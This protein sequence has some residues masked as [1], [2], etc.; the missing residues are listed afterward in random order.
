MVI[1]ALVV[2]KLPFLNVPYYWDEAWPYSTATHIM[3]NRGLSFM[4]DAI[5]PFISRGHPLMFFFLAAA[6]MKVFGAG[7]I[8]VHSFALAISAATLAATFAF[9]RQFFSARAGFMATLLLSVQAVFISQ[10]AF[11][12]PEMIMALW[13]MVCLHAWFANGK[14]VFVIAGAAMLL[15]KESGAVLIAT[16]GLS[17]LLPFAKHRQWSK[18]LS[19]WSLLL[20]SVLIAFI[21]FVLQKIYHGW[22][23]FP[24]Y[25][26]YISS[27]W[28]VAT[29][30]LLSASEYVF[31]YYGRNGLSGLLILSAVTI[32]ARKRR[33]YTPLQ[34]HILTAL[35]GYIVMYMIFSCINYY[36][37]RYL[38]C[39]FPPFI[40]ICAAALDSA[41]GRYRL[42]RAMAVTG[43]SATCLF[44]YINQGY[45]G[46]NDYLPSLRVAQKM[47]KYCEEAGLKDKHIFAPSVVRIDLTE[48][49]AGFL[50]GSPFSQVQ[51]EAD[52]HTEYCIFTRD[53]LNE[54]QRNQLKKDLNL[55]LVSRFDMGYAWSE[56][57]KVIR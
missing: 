10:S 20:C 44:F 43:L 53:E 24:F 37:P 11:L 51:A 55:Q 57:Y 19:Q 41:F 28:Q 21:Y 13:T 54:Q 8:S 16:L 9:C 32:A 23:L 33:E 47:V 5:P 31:I 40:I 14:T 1:A 46:D 39:A 52:A 15:T 26:G 2:Y 7:F 30:N 48:P 27:H 49:Y 6:W 42:L 50:A 25:T 3:Y 12:M 36:I 34:K 38:L 29:Q 56:L 22:F 18:L 4:P 35:A 17:A 45:G